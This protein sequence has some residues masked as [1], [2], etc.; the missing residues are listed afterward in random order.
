M[1]AMVGLLDGVSRISAHDFENGENRGHESSKKC[2]KVPYDL[3]ITNIQ[4]PKF[5]A[6][7]NRFH[8]C[9]EHKL[10]FALTKKMSGLRAPYNSFGNRN[11]KLTFESI[12]VSTVNV[13]RCH[14]FHSYY[15]K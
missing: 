7:I 8:I 1:F 12:A 6:F 9:K 10:S 2:L 4:N 5:F 13:R 11:E 15:R 14:N 3:K